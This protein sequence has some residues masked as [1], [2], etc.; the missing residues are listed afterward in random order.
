MSGRHPFS[1]L[2]KDFT[3]ERRRRVD[4]LKAKILA[5][6]PMHELRQARKLTQ[7]ELAAELDVQQPAIAKLEH[8][9]DMYVSTLRSYIEAVGGRLKIVAE[10]RDGEVEITNFRSVGEMAGDSVEEAAEEAHAAQP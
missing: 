4:A 5:E 3:P 1:N 6:M 2:T 10:F 7:R 8:R 9:T